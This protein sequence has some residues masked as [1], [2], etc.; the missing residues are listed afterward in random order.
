LGPAIPVASRPRFPDSPPRSI[1]RNS[2]ISG[3]RRPGLRLCVSQH[4]ALGLQIYSR[5]SHHGLA[6]G[7][8]TAF[9]SVNLFR[10]SSTLSCFPQAS[11]RPQDTTLLETLSAPKG[12]KR[13]AQLA[14]ALHLRST[15]RTS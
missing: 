7:F 6:L 5:G 8:A 2:A 15:V 9:R 3:R 11:C 4:H 10:H 13:E 1:A 14:E 12:V